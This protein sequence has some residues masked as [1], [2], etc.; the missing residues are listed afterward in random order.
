MAI[1]S[2]PATFA[3][4]STAWRRITETINNILSFKF[5][6]SRIR[7]A[8]E[9]AA[10][11]IPVNFAYPPGNVLRYGTNATPG[12]TDMTAAFTAAISQW[13]QGGASVY[14]PAGTYLVGTILYP[15]GKGFR[16]VGDGPDAT[17][18]V[19][20]ANNIPVLQ[21]VQSAGTLDQ[22][23]FSGF[24]VKA[25]ASAGATS[26]STAIDCSGMRTCTIEK[27]FG[28]SNAGG[29]GFASLFSLS[30]S[31]Y[32]CYGNRHSD[33]GLDGQTGWTKAWD[34]N[35][36][37]TTNAANNANDNM[38]LN[39]WIYSNTGLTW[40]IDARRTANVSIIGG[41]IEGN[42]SA[43]A[44]N[45]GTMTTI[46]NVWIESNA[47]TIAYSTATDGS[48]NTGVVLGCYFSTA[49]TIDFTGCQGNAWIGN[50]EAGDQT[51]TNNNGTNVRFKGSVD[52]Q[53]APTIAY[54]S[55]Q[56]GTLTLGSATLLDQ[57][58]LA[59]E[60]SYLLQYTWTPGTA[61]TFS[62]FTVT[63]TNNWAIVAMSVGMTR[64]ASGQPRA[65]AIGSQTT[66]STDNVTND[67]HAITVLLRVKH[68]DP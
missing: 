35:N 22:G 17:V 23:H 39:P 31:P 40:G 66:F 60:L 14:V 68:T 37:G 28:I 64:N 20:N 21:K 32:L 26:T 19:A 30:A 38:I 53:I 18:L 59:N 36:G 56:T 24:S 43:T 11:V 46:Q 25:N 65:V 41:L 57:P 6:A 3:D 5:D 1:P 50:T 15:N 13:S 47:H 55:G 63:A 4:I 52:A 27:V 61:A 58:N 9:I 44:V 45:S 49:D 7:T 54:T 2:L 8:A 42:T 51:W 10:G 33:C 29:F 34:F 62:L 67:A 12:T 16:F 48:G